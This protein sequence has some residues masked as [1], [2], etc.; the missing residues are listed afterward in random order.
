M[1]TCIH[2]YRDEFIHFIAYKQ[3][4]YETYSYSITH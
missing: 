2:V 4:N 3:V 1:Y